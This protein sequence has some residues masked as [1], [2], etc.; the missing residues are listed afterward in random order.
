MLLIDTGIFVSA[1]DRNRPFTP[2][3]PPCC[4][5]GP[6]WLSPHPSSPKPLGSSKPASAPPPRRDSSPWSRSTIVTS[7]RAPHTPRRL[8]T[9]PLRR[10]LDA[11]VCRGEGRSRPG[12]RQAQESPTAPCPQ[13][14]Y[15]GARC[16]FCHATRMS[17]LR[18]EIRVP[19]DGPHQRRRRRVAPRSS[20]CRGIPTVHVEQAEPIAR[21]QGPILVT[22]LLLYPVT[23]ML[24]PSKATATGPV[25]VV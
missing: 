22:L 3:A 24:V 20:R 6:I 4:A 23:Q 12:R 9:R 7:S 14:S 16:N 25:P 18:S 15:S 13:N 21:G 1:A 11:R 19:V 2:H 8:P 5:T 10:P 17:A